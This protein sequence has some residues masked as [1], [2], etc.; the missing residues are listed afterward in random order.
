MFAVKNNYI[1]LCNENDQVLISKMSDEKERLLDTDGDIGY[2]NKGST[3]DNEQDL[4]SAVKLIKE[5]SEVLQQLRSKLKEEQQKNKAF[6]SKLQKLQN[7][8]EKLNFLYTGLADA[9]NEELE[10]LQNTFEVQKELQASV[11]DELRFQMQS[12]RN[13]FDTSRNHL[14]ENGATSPSK[15]PPSNPK[16]VALSED[17]PKRVLRKN[18]DD[19][20]GTTGS[21]PCL[22]S[23]LNTIHRGEIVWRINGFTKKLKKIQ[24]GSYD[25]PSRSEPFTTGPFGYRLSLWAYLNGRGKGDKKCLSLYVRVMAGEF[26]PVLNW[27]IKP[28]Y[29]FYLISQDSDSNKRLDLVRVRDLSIKHNGISRPHKD[30]K[31]I[32]VG[33]DDFIV[34][35]DIEKK[36]FLLDDSLFIKCVVEVPQAF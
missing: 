19:S 32:I 26:D 22:L 15:L 27:P 5:Q 6:E 34:H 1:V 20:T 31:S 12:I 2:K 16:L 36:N 23:R 8:F 17:S 7:D 25:D 10:K 3:N 33:F 21:S 18:S 9:K 29:T 30:D 13:K 14:V 24:S 4:S 28:C 11:V 35:E